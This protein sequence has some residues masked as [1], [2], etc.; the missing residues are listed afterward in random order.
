MNTAPALGLQL[1]TVRDAQLPLATLLE[2]VAAAGYTGVET[3]DTHGLDPLELR[4]LIDAAGLQVTSSH[5]ALETLRNDTARVAAAHKRLGT[6]VVVVPWLAPE[7]RP[8]DLLGW[9]AFGRELAAIGRALAWDGLALAY[10]HHDFELAPLAS[11]CGLAA[12][13]EATE[14]EQLQVELDTGWLVAS[15][16]DPVRWLRTWTERVTRVHVKDHRPGNDPPWV[17]VGTG[18]L[19]LTALVD[20]ARSH[21]VDWLIVEHDQPS[22]PLAT[23]E[24]SATAVRSLL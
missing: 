22:D 12:L 4:G 20:T 11:S 5:V 3:L 9:G 13:L 8:T 21:G 14:P 6:P 7:E 15:G 17:D 16:E 19:P 24:R 18:V 1:Y 10:H 2:R 23:M